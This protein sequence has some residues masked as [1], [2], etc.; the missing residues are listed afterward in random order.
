MTSRQYTSIFTSKWNR[1]SPNSLGKGSWYT[2]ALHCADEFR[3]AAETFNTMLHTGTHTRLFTSIRISLAETLLKH[4]EKANCASG[5]L[6]RTPHHSQD[7][8]PNEWVAL[9]SQH[10]LGAM[11][12]TLCSFSCKQKSFHLSHL[13]S[14]HLMYVI[15][16]L[17]YLIISDD[18]YN[19][20]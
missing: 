13:L 16:F 7:T 2:L 12:I 4:Q 17:T 15:L 9:T 19:E 10:G 6:R 5:A 1:C 14:T 18:V 8:P 3:F 11:G 20:I